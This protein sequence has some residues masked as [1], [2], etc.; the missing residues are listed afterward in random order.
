MSGGGSSNEATGTTLEQLFAMIVVVV[1]AMIGGMLVNLLKGMNLGANC[2]CK[3]GFKLPALSEKITIPPLVGM[4]VMGC[5]ARNFFGSKMDHLN[6]DWSEWVRMVCLSVILLR[7]GLELDFEGK[8]LTVVLLTLCP[9][10]VEASAAAVISKIIFGF[11][12]SICV[13]LGFVLAAVS[14]AVVVPSC[15]KL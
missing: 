4:I 11:T 8:G 5:I 1:C 12:W 7:G 14:P 10:F 2:C 3:K 15:M 13:A 9:Q 6:D